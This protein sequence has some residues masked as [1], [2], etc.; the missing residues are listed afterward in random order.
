MVADVSVEMMVAGFVCVAGKYTGLPI[1]DVRCEN[2]HITA[3]IEA[4]TA[5][6]SPVL[7]W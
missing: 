1:G 5:T 3:P 6:I 7:P 4:S 2:V